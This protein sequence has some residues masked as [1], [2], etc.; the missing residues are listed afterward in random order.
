MLPRA[1]CDQVG[2]DS[3]GIGGRQADAFFF[4]HVANFGDPRR[5]LQREGIGERVAGAAARLVQLAALLQLTQRADTL[6]MAL[7]PRDVGRIGLRQTGRATG[8]NAEEDQMQPCC[9]GLGDAWGQR[10]GFHKSS[11]MTLRNQTGP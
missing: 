2:R 8:D 9:R 11:P 7:G 10:L 6:E 3:A 5:W 1:H 4:A